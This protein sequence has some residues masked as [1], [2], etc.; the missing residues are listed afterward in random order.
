MLQAVY[1]I[2]QVRLQTSNPTDF[3]GGVVP[4]RWNLPIT[5]FAVMSLW[6]VKIFYIGLF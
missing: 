2:A 3:E 6:T 4:N 5:N 1:F